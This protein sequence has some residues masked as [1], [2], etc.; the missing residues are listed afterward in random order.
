MDIKKIFFASLLFSVMFSSLGWAEFSLT[1]TITVREEYNDNIYLERDKEYDYITYVQPSLI[2]EWETKLATLNLNFGLDYEKYARN[3]SEDELRPSHGS[4]MKSTFNLYHDKLLLDVSDNYDRVPID[5]AKKGAVGNT[6]VNLTDRNCF[7]LNPYL[8][9]EPMRNM[10]ARFDYKYENVWYEDDDGDDAETHNYLVTLTQQITGRLSADLS[11]GFTQYRP[12]NTSKSVLD[13][14]GAEQYDR[15]NVNLGFLWQVNELLSLRANCGYSW[16]NYD[17]S[18]D[19]DAWQYGAQ[20]DY[21]MTRVWSA[22]FVY[23]DDISASV[24]DGARDQQK[25]SAYFAYAD[26][27][28]I[29]ITFFTTRDD[30]LE[31]DRLDESWGGTVNGEVPITNKKGI[32]WLANYTDFSEGH[33]QDYQR[34]GGRIELYQQMRL[35]RMS[36]GYTYNRNNSDIADN[37]YIN[38]IVLIK[39]TLT[40]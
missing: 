3:S 39:V 25:Y 15:K 21:Q 5:D 24:D 23:Q 16:L 40:W 29:K 34:Y 17:F 18:T 32:T 19:Y 2:M 4:Q 31:I 27:S 9:L 37:D 22:G 38:N 36:L 33:I 13:A 35:G 14:S 26:R 30:Y 8:L 7:V 11:G 6:L 20:A 28:K 10:Q 1:P 12:K